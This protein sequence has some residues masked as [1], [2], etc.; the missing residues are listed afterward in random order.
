MTSPNG[1][2]LV[3]ITA[4]GLAGIVLGAA[5]MS[6][7]RAQTTTTPAYLIGNTQEIRDPE[8]YKQYQA[9]ASPTT[10]PY[11]ARVI[12]RGMPAQIDTQ[13]TLPRGSIIIIQFPSMKNLRDWWNSPE[14]SAARPLREKST[15]GQTYVMEGAPT[16]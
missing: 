1:S 4:T 2:K 10:T 6:A 9:K 7:L 12:A 5:G 8:M 14:Y 15:V 16:S 3:Q 13:S 11:G